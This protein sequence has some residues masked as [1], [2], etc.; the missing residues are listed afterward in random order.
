MNI[1]AHDLKAPLNRILGLTNVMEL[2]GG[3]PAKQLEYLKLI[4]NS[5][6]A[7]SSLIIDLLD[8]N[9]IEEKG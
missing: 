6:R 4:K 9:A 3:L 1:V 8:V 5:T 7:G 2:E